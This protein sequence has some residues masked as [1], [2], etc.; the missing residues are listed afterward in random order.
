MAKTEGTVIADQAEIALAEGLERVQYRFSVFPV[1]ITTRQGQKLVGIV[2]PELAGY[3]WMQDKGHIHIPIGVWDEAAISVHQGY[4]K[5]IC[6]TAGAWGVF[7]LFANKS[8]LDVKK[9]LG[10][11]ERQSLN[12]II[13]F[14]HIIFDEISFDT[15]T[16]YRSRLNQKDVT[17]PQLAARLIVDFV[18]EFPGWRVEPLNL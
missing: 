5:A 13:N 6:D 10:L 12:F 18:N 1:E 16:G 2:E 14:S 9:L 17:R 3:E 8:D 4:Q 7:A 15:W 11:Q